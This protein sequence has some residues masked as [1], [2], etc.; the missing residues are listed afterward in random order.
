M[1]GDM[2][3]LQY[4]CIVKAKVPVFV[5]V[6]FLAIG[7]DNIYAPNMFGSYKSEL[8]KL[9][10]VKHRKITGDFYSSIKSYGPSK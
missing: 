8:S 5:F 10:C 6:F 1:K 2:F 9:K 4:T 3:D 7:I